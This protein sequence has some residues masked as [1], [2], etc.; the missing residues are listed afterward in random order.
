MLIGPLVLKE[1]IRRRELVFMGVLFAGL[2]LFFVGHEA[3][4]ATA[5]HP[6]QGNMVA[7]APVVLGDHGG[8]S[9]TWG[10]AAGTAGAGAAV[11]A[12]N[13]IACLA[14]SPSRCRS[15]TC[16]RRIWRSSRFS[17]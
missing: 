9:G 16:R 2:A 4:R 5:P 17:G 10:V 6:F 14:A 15:A 12:G 8:R 7:L 1:P 3:P 13:V 11:V